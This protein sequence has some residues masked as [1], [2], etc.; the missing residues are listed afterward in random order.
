MAFEPEKESLATLRKW[1][2]LL[3]IRGVSALRKPDMVELFNRI[4][5]EKVAYVIE[6]DKN[7]RAARGEELSEPAP[8]KRGRPRK[9][10]LPEE[11]A[12][13]PGEEETAV[14][15]LPEEEIEKVE[16]ARKGR[17]LFFRSLEARQPVTA[18]EEVA[19]SDDGDL[20]GFTIESAEESDK[21]AAPRD[22]KYSSISFGSASRQNTG[23]AGYGT[24][25]ASYKPQNGEPGPRDVRGGTQGRRLT[26]LPGYDRSQPAAPGR[27][28]QAPSGNYARQAPQETEARTPSFRP[29][30]RY[31]SPDPLSRDSRPWENRPQ[32]SWQD[33]DSEYRET[34]PVRSGE[35]EDEAAI[36]A[37]LESE[38]D[39][40]QQEE[41]SVKPEG[42][43]V[44]GILEVMDSYGFLRSANYLPGDRDV[45]VSASQ[46]HRFRLKTGDMVRGIIRRNT[47]KF[48]ALY[49]ITEINDEPLSVALN[50]KSFDELTPVF[51]DQ[52]I[53]LETDPEEWS[54][55]LM[56]L[57]A[58]IGKGQRGMIVSPPKAGKTT[59]IK[60]IAQAVTRNH[61]EIQLLILLIDERPEE[62][63]DIR[64]SIGG[65][66]TE[67]I[68]STF[69]ETPDH[70]KRVAEMV[71]GRAKRLV[72][73]GRDVMILLDSIT[74]LARAYNL[75]VAP[76]G[77]T[78]SGG[79][80]PTAL[81][82]PKRFFGAARN[83]R[84]G[85]SLTILATALV[86]T[87]SR[88]DDMVFEEFKG[89][90]NMELV[91][92][93]ALSERRIFP[94]IDL[95][96]SGTRRDDK[97]LSEDEAEAVGTLRRALLGSRGGDET[98]EKILDLMKHTATNE[99]FCRLAKKFR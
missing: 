95:A 80:D 56:D 90:G 54:M 50:R 9:N 42:E 4:G 61:P 59:M 12:A 77:R 92:D 21:K 43:E 99:E 53:R 8:K 29:V 51:P 33:E 79:L 57:L 48:A 70:H 85:G 35:E 98:V 55:R 94:A 91:L 16:E 69:D 32:Q 23:R 22:R 74:R 2:D 63:T 45:Y 30:D 6:K 34:A 88:L 60:K 86:D 18:R 65:Q 67:V 5:P 47:E 27:Y 96:K 3:G 11:T 28:P 68:Y 15:L 64:E 62:V 20:D 7:E 17:Q 1:A 75:I 78:L 46:I 38:E 76:S 36:A 73:H 58:P 93:R 44:S 72:E 26:P 84:E 13:L 89:T 82:A 37:M 19:E 39:G 52:R 40:K 25:S 24:Y 87:G 71:L 97:L 49:Y 41:T 83:M 81:Y 10:P 66:N 31:T 14:E